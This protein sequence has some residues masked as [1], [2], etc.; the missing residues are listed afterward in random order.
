[1]NMKKT[2]AGLM[3]GVVA[4]SA[5]ATVAVSAKAQESR[6]KTWSTS[7][8]Q[9]EK[10][11]T[12]A[13]KV[14]VTLTPATTAATDDET[15]V[16]IEGTGTV[17]ADGYEAT[18]DATYTFDGTVW[19]PSLPAGITVTGA[20]DGDV[21]TVDFTAG[22]AATTGNAWEKGDILTV[23]DSSVKIDSLIKIVNRDAGSAESITDDIDLYCAIVK[24]GDDNTN[25]IRFVSDVPANLDGR[26]IELQFNVTDDVEINSGDFN[27]TNVSISGSDSSSVTSVAN[28][29][30]KLEEKT[31][32]K[33][34]VLNK[35]NAAGVDC[36]DDWDGIAYVRNLD[37]AIRG[38]AA[39]AP[40][41]SVTDKL[42]VA[43]PTAE[44][45]DYLMDAKGATITFNFFEKGI[46]ESDST[47]TFEDD[48]NR[49]NWDS[50]S[51]KSAISLRVNNSN[52]LSVAMK[53]FDTE[54]F[55]ATFEWD[56]VMAKFQGGS[57]T[58]LV[59]TLGFKIDNDKLPVL[60]DSDPEE[61]ITLELK[62]ITIKVPEMAETEDNTMVEDI[63]KDFAAGE[64]ATVVEDTLPAASDAPAATDAPA[65]TD[66]AAN[67]ETGNS[68]AALLA[69]PA[70]LAAAAIVAKKRG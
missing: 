69:I 45:M 4:I 10:E 16:T 24:S 53:D 35:G 21:V 41:N 22:T 26:V 59:N 30:A 43:E 47:V 61:K 64:S 68:A 19:T 54:K 1:M 11:G 42:K 23:G 28:A 67:P 56:D 58:G 8:T 37:S 32:D 52:V 51:V 48:N 27:T 3:A 38:Q 18:E 20:V 63:V 5:M 13:A 66:A 25:K 31:V 44:M 29:A 33:G 7:W 70:A 60:K 40:S 9:K 12:K 39:A 49:F 65:T 46:K 2:L 6:E 14:I 62:S 15:V 17:S 57:Y 36:A 50:S 34:I 55:A